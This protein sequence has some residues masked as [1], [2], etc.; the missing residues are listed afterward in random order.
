MLHRSFAL[1]LIAVLVVF[2]ACDE[3]TDVPAVDHEDATDTAAVDLQLAEGE[4][5]FACGDA[6]SFSVR[7][8]ADTAHVRLPETS[9]TLAQ[10]PA[11]SGARYAADGYDLHMK[12]GEAI[13]TTPEATFQ[14]CVRRDRASVWEEARERGVTMRAMGQEPGW[15][16]EVW[17]DERMRISADYG[18]TSFEVDDVERESAEHGYVLQGR[19]EGRQ[20][21]VRVIDEHCTDVMSGERFERTVHLVI[22]GEEYRG[23][24]RHIH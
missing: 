19:G 17:N 11:A 9:L 23:C 21:E 8:S 18:E 6:M 10:V 15:V 22:D 12:S 4:T 1:T 20:V 14:D 24:G 7:F 2:S 3:P 16:V 13:M 5:H